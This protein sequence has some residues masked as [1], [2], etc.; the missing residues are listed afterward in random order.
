MDKK[1][2]ARERARS[3]RLKNPD[4]YRQYYLKNKNKL[5][6][7][8]RDYYASHAVECREKT[9]NYYCKNR[10]LVLKKTK[11]KYIRSTRVKQTPEEKRSLSVKRMS[12]WQKK[13]PER[14]NLKNSLWCKLNKPK[15]NLMASERRFV[16]NKATLGAPKQEILKFYEEARLKSIQTGV[17]HV[18][19]HIIPVSGK[20]VCGLHVPWNLRVI[21]R[22]ENCKKSNKVIL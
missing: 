3:W 17:P 16:K 22:S 21:T 10:E 1:E 15:V 14:V 20:T 11:E 8:S 2:R 6:Q 7:K 13:Y 19:D 4:R 12:E 5:Q 18:V 9:R